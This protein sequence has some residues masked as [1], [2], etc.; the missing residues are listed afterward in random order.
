M[1]ALDSDARFSDIALMD[2]I[3]DHVLNGDGLIT[4][5]ESGVGIFQWP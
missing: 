5:C 1:V 4:W 2:T 3:Q